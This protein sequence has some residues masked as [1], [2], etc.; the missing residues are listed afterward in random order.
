MGR[1][2]FVSVRAIRLGG[3]IAAVLLAA[4][5]AGVAQAQSAPTPPAMC[6]IDAAT[7]E[8][9]KTVPIDVIGEELIRVQRGV[10]PNHATGVS[11]RNYVLQPNGTWIDSATGELAKTRPIDVIGEELI[12]VQRGVDPN[13]ATGVSGR[14]YVLVPCPPPAAPGGHASLPPNP[15]LKGG[16]AGAAV[17][18]EINFARTN[19]AEYAKT[20]LQNPRTSATDEAVTLLD[21]QAPLAPVTASPMLDVA[22][23]RH[24]ADQGPGGLTGH[25]GTDGSTARDRIQGAGVYSMIIAEDISLGQESAGGVVR[26]LIIDERN[27]TRMH[28]S[29]IFNPLLKFAGV[30]GGPHK[31]YHSM[32][33]IDLSGAMMTR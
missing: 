14:N 33:V 16:C 13:H 32:C 1:G 17:L 10:D 12:R 18:A 3:A 26:Q 22:A 19:P 28:R 6:W 23:A 21:H 2:K 24:A 5:S 7:G 20:L 31:V 9:A 30:G 15:G 8:R 11:G 4:A 29:D 27:P 25:T